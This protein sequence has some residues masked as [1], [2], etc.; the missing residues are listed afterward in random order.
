MKPSKLTPRVLASELHMSVPFL[1]RIA[2]HVDGYYKPTRLQRIKGK[3]RQIDPPT[4]AFKKLLKRL[5]RFL[6]RDFDFHPAAHGGVRR[7]SCFTA[8]TRHKGRQFIITRDVKDCY[9]SITADS[10]RR[11]L[12]RLGFR[13]DA[14][15]LL[16]RLMTVHDRLPQG[17]PTSG[18]ALNFFLYDADEEVSSV[19]T[20]SAARYTRT[21]DDMVVSV[22]SMDA[23]NAHVAMLE[24]QIE[25]HGLKVSQRKRDKHGLQPSHKQ[26]RVHNIVVNNKRGTGIVPEHVKEAIRRAEDYVIAARCVSAD[27]LEAVALKRSRVH[28]WMYYCRQA[29][30][31][32]ARHLR[33]LLEQGDRLVCRRLQIEQVTRTRRWWLNIPRENRPKKLALR[34][35]ELRAQAVPAQSQEPSLAGAR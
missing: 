35:R 7:R 23:V 4:Y 10:L 1:V 20:T 14:A 9:P 33:R 6:Q 25:E 22:C 24:T 19:C 30:F 28:G 27:S 29:R 2:C 18:D 32:P 13:S 34:W 11:R 8:A 31:S 3:L 21:A 17:A 26:Q 16:C 15:W 12:L 5:H